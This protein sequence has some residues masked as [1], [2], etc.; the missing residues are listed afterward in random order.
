M[1]G[2]RRKRNLS[3]WLAAL[4]TAALCLLSP[5]P[6]WADGDPVKITR[7]GEDTGFENLQAAFSAVQDGDVITLLA[8]AELG[9][10]ISIEK[11]LTLELNGFT[12]NSSGSTFLV[13]DGEFTIKDNGRGET[14]GGIITTIGRAITVSLRGALNFCGGA[15]NCHGDNGVGILNLGN[16]TVS[17]G[18][19][20]C[21]GSENGYGIEHIG[22]TFNLSGSPVISGPTADI[23]LKSNTV[24]NINNPLTAPMTTGDNPVSDP[25]TVK[26][27][28]IDDS[29]TEPYIFT[30]GFSTNCL[31]GNDVA[32]P[33]AYFV[34][35]NAGITTRLVDGT[36]EGSK[37]AQ[38]M[39]YA[40]PSDPTMTEAQHADGYWIGDELTST[41][42]AIPAD[43]ITWQ[44]YRKL[45]EGDPIAILNATGSGLSTTYTV[46]TDDY[47]NETQTG[48]QI[49]A[50]ATMAAG[51]AGTGYPAT[52]ISVS[53]PKT[54]AV[55]KKDNYN[56]LPEIQIPSDHVGR[57]YV[58]IADASP[59]VEYLV[60][61]EDAEVTSNYWTRAQSEP[62]Q[63]ITNYVTIDEDG[64]VV[65]KNMLPST[66]YQLYYRLKE[67]EDTKPGSTSTGN[68]RV[69][70]F[71]T[72]EFDRRLT[73]GDVTYQI[74]K[75]ADGTAYAEVVALD[76]KDDE[77]HPGR[78]TVNVNG[79]IILKESFP[80]EDLEIYEAMG[81]IM[82]VIPVVRF[83]DNLIDLSVIGSSI[84][85]YG[86]IIVKNFEMYFLM[87]DYGTATPEGYQIFGP[88]L[89]GYYVLSN[90]TEYAM[91]NKNDVLTDN[92]TPV[93]GNLN[94]GG[95][96]KFYDYFDQEL[97]PETSGENAGK[98][99]FAKGQQ[100]T[101]TVKLPTNFEFAGGPNEN[102]ELQLTDDSDNSIL[103]SFSLS[104]SDEQDIW[105]GVFNMPPYANTVTISF[106]EP[107]MI[108][109]SEVEEFTYHAPDVSAAT[110]TADA[111]NPSPVR[112]K[113]PL[114]YT[115]EPKHT[116]VNYYTLTDLGL[117]EGVEATIVDANDESEVSLPTEKKVKVT[118]T[119]PPT[120]TGEE[121]T[122]APNLALC[123][124]DIT[125]APNGTITYYDTKGL[126]YAGDND[127]VK[128]STV[129]DISGTTVTVTEINTKKIP[130]RTPFFIMNTSNAQ[131]IRM[132]IGNYEDVAVADRFLGTA[133]EKNT[134]DQ[135]FGPW[136][137]KED[138]KYYGFNGTDF[139]WIREP[140]NVAAHRCW[141]Q[142]A[143]GGTGGAL[144]RMLNIDWPDGSATGISTINAGDTDSDNWYDLNGRKLQGKP[145]KK[146][147][148]IR[149]GQKMVVK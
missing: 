48:Y 58:T 22:G 134:S 133:E 73:I 20:N 114:V 75:E 77:E 14:P 3:A 139:V 95:E 16:L 61:E 1:N 63:K 2:K 11:D 87:A 129:T 15:I 117:T 97:T 71:T 50:V 19:I 57:N 29:P 34:N 90:G 24:I 106:V 136:N 142:L 12:V 92:M 21:S 47:D 110:V 120:F 112:M 101:V 126:K 98:I 23:H 137:M 59:E 124:E 107:E 148:Y 38:F 8:D 54:T 78:K 56:E 13:Q 105:T 40:V 74:Y 76:I 132:E 80:A 140:G 128:F 121:V 89:N 72:E 145:Q 55:V 127:G 85:S 115:I 118:L 49:Y 65:E 45:G 81:Y 88:F 37:E 39:Q 96:V 79:N 66:Y 83:D 102:F 99:L 113:Q 138:M 116:G 52:D 144:A 131:S 60:V 43:G 46:S 100:V 111:G 5:M 62:E 18:T 108:Q 7:N 31:N 119:V 109:G 141:I 17:G 64:N 69:I 103:K 53:S 91:A 104:Y 10:T 9:S 35:N 42:V 44:W 30:S 125:I 36:I 70:P 32:D 41:T 6:A 130:A 67:T 25:W 28:N 4:C 33:A 94:T 82:D 122:F 86:Y 51:A 146:G 84:E 123:A 26:S 93:L 68:E 147:L 149:N 135:G 143:T 27:D